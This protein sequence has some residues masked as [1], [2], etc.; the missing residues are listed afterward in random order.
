M[1]EK[2]IE[3]L[4]KEKVIEECFRFIQFSARALRKMNYKCDFSFV[5]MQKK[6][7]TFKSFTCTA[8]Q[9]RVMTTETYTTSNSLQN[10]IQVFIQSLFIMFFF[11]LHRVLRGIESVF[12]FLAASS[13]NNNNSK[14]NAVASLFQILKLSLDKW[15][16]GDIINMFLF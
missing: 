3:N 5:E 8:L 7:K 1:S 14:L 15:H 11:L 10:I 6:K 2:M 16:K 9:T 4:V 12:I 13:Y